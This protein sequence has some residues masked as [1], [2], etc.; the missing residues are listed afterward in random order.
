[1][2]ENITIIMFLIAF[3]TFLMGRIMFMILPM[4]NEAKDIFFSF[5]DF[6]NCTYRHILLC[7]YITLLGLYVSYKYFKKN[8]VPKLKFNPKSCRTF[9]I[10]RKAKIAIWLTCP[11]AFLIIFDKARYVLTHGYAGVFLEYQTSLPT[12][13]IMLYALFEYFTFLFLATLPSKREAKPILLLYSLIFCVNILGGDRGESMLAIFVVIYYL[14]LR[15]KLYSEDVIWL[16]KK[17]IR[18]LFWSIPVTIVILLLVSF[19]REKTD[20]SNMNPIIMFE[21]FFYQQ[22]V[23]VNVIGCTYDEYSTL[24]KDKLYSLG[25]ITDYFRNNYLMKFLFD[26][27]VYEVGSIERALKGNSLDAAITYTMSPKTYFN[28][29]GMGSSFIA[30]AWH[31]FGYVGV[32][33]YSIF[34]GYILAKIPIWNARNVWISTIALVFFKYICYAP[35]ARALGFVASAFSVSFWPLA[36]IIYLMSILK[37]PKR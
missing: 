20:L 30:E 31:D 19:T 36:L 21:G 5:L 9:Y 33:I 8:N 27:D 7:L 22:G 14:F 10:R 3:F 17:G 23:S 24:A 16:S 28:G 2:N 35:R 11:F 6:S 26:I 18:I 15:N 37:F 4:N 1:M 12:F 29:G 25:A 34:Y 32:L 13:F